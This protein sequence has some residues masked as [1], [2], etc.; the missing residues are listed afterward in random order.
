MRSRW[1]VMDASHGS[2]M[3]PQSGWQPHS[4]TLVPP[5]RLLPQYLTPSASLGHI[6]RILRVVHDG[7][8][9]LIDTLIVR[10]SWAAL[11]LVW[12]VGAVRAKP[13]LRATGLNARITSFATIVLGFFLIGSDWAPRWL[14]A[15]PLLAGPAVQGTGAALTIMG[16]SFAIWAR[17]ALGTNWSGRPT[18]KADH[19]LVVRG[20]YALA[21]H[22]IYTGILVAAIGTGV[23]DLQWRRVLG[24]VMIS[25]A[26]L[27]KIRQEERL[28][29]DAFPDSYPLYQRQVRMLIPGLF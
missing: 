18:V 2:C 28:M 24:V 26:L 27:F 19:E 13:A 20:P 9:M 5:H 23:T 4:A 3:G 6:R 10:Y 12:L 16:C 7:V 14:L 17:L 15:P 8:T 22:P 1:G 21:R 11:V 25:L 29:L